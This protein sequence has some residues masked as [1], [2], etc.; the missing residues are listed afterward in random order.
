MKSDISYFI[1]LIA[2][3]STSIGFLNILPI[4]ILDGGHLVMFAYE[5]ITKRK[6]NQKPLMTA[7]HQIN[8]L[9]DS[10]MSQ[11]GRLIKKQKLTGLELSGTEQNAIGAKTG[12]GELGY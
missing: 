1:P 6:P 3:I 2:I 4:P 10:E 5:G 11:G 8:A 9:D 12:S 7:E